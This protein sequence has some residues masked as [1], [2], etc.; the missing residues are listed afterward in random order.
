METKNLSLN[1][2]TQKGKLYLPNGEVIDELYLHVAETYHS[3]IDEQTSA[4]FQHQCWVPVLCY[5]YVRNV[6]LYCN[7]FTVAA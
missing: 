4:N 2:F 7:Y 1:N 3:H 6:E 5:N